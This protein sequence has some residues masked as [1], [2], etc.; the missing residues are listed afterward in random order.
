[1]FFK[2]VHKSV[3]IALLH[4]RAKSHCEASPRGEGQE[5]R[6]KVQETIQNSFQGVTTIIIAHR[7]SSTYHCDQ[8]IELADGK[9]KQ[10]FQRKRQASPA[11]HQ[12]GFSSS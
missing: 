11:S 9:V 10:I 4:E 5:P 2:A 1:M 7:P 12:L 6:P 3:R 8:V